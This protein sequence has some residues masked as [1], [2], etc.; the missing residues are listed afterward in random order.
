MTMA[1][2]RLSKIRDHLAETGGGSVAVKV[3][4]ILWRGEGGREGGK[5][6]HGGA[7]TRH[8]EDI[9]GKKDED[10]KEGKVAC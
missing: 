6:T 7:F 10:K 1:N 5:D 9:D 2:A 8:G 4:L 3:R